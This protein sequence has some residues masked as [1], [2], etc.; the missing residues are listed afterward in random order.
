M[1]V[2]MVSGLLLDLAYR[3]LAVDHG[4]GGGLTNGSNFLFSTGAISA[5]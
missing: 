4:A 2:Q 3:H 5:F 1:T